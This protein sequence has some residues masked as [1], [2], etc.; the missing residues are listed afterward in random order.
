MLYRGDVIITNI[1]TSNNTT[2]TYVKLLIDLQG[3]VAEFIVVI[4]DASSPLSETDKAE[5]KSKDIE[6]LSNV[7]I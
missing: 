4:G 2:Y 3:Q 1:Q 5:K 7:R 6:H